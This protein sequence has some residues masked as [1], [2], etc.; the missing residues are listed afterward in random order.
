MREIKR[1]LFNQ[2]PAYMKTDEEQRRFVNSV[3]VQQHCQYGSA[4]KRDCLRF[5]PLYVLNL[6]PQAAIEQSVESTPWI[7]S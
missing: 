1:E 6:K 7:I 4:K 2:T 5:L 3:I